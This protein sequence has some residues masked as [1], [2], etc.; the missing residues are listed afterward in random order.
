MRG[1]LIRTSNK[2]E[3][4]YGKIVRGLEPTAYKE[5]CIPDK[6][7]LMI[8]MW[9]SLNG[10]LMKCKHVFD[11]QRMGIIIYGWLQVGM[12]YL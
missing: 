10:L 8:V 4:V 9:D 12:S 11:E 1:I 2:F 3:A 7:T 5:K 6:L